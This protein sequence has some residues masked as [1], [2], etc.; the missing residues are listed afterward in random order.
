MI[1]KELTYAAFMEA[2]QVMLAEGQ[3]PSVRVLRARLGGG[4]NSTIVEYLRRWRSESA[5]EESAAGHELSDSIKSSL[6]A[7][8][9]RVAQIIRTDESL[10][11][12]QI[13]A[14]LQ[15]TAELLKESETRYQELETQLQTEQ[16][17]AQQSI[18]SLEKQLSTREERINTLEYQIQKF[19]EQL[20]TTLIEQ[21]TAHHT[22][23]KAE[24]R[25]ELAEEMILKLETQLTDASRE[26]ETLKQAL[27]A[28][29]IQ[30][31]VLKSHTAIEN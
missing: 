7:E 20:K 23:A 4:S 18:L 11:R 17:T 19:S 1:K 10:Q 27:K 14:Q 13:E 3:K 9:G 24:G 6:R 28:A 5:L 12:A 15:E 22:A 30:V 21:N 26:Q 29:E 31:A 8:F 2:L 25:A 16:A